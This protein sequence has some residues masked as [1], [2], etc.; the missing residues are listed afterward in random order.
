MSQPKDLKSKSAT[1]TPPQPPVRDGTDELA[2]AFG[3]EGTNKRLSHPLDQPR[4]A[5]QD[6]LAEGHKHVENTP[7]LR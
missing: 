4:P 1:P 2:E 6:P 3:R 7:F 5:D